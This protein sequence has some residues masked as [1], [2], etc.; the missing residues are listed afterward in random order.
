MFFYNYINLILLS[1]FFLNSSIS[2]NP[3]FK[4]NMNWKKKTIKSTSSILPKVDSVANVVLK[5]N[6]QIINY[7]LELDF[8]DETQKKYVVLSVINQTRS[9]DRMGAKILDL[10]YNF[11]DKIM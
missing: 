2:F 3:F 7:V 6:E 11:I 1:S 5:A 4:N 10:Y 9:G 8:L